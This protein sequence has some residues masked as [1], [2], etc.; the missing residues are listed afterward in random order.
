MKIKSKKIILTILLF[1]ALGNYGRMN[2]TEN[3]RTVEFLSIFAIG[4]LSSLLVSEI[5][6]KDNEDEE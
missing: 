5:F 1:A 3:I 6:S 2:G 4:A